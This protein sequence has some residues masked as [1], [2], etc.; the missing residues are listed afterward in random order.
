MVG[1]SPR[2]NCDNSP[3]SMKDEPSQTTHSDQFSIQNDTDLNPIKII[4]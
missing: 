2:A 1:D 3:K 4:E